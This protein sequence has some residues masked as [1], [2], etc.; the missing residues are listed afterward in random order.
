MIYGVR[1]YRPADRCHRSRYCAGARRFAASVARSAVQICILG[2]VFGTSLYHSCSRRICR[3]TDRA[4]ATRAR[5][6]AACARCRCGGARPCEGDMVV[7][8]LL[9][10]DVIGA[11][12][13]ARRPTGIYKEVER[14]REQPPSSCREPKLREV[15]LPQADG[16][17]L[18]VTVLADKHQI[19][20]AG[21]GKFSIAQHDYKIGRSP[22]DCN[23]RA[24]KQRGGC[25]PLHGTSSPKP[26]QFTFGS[27]SPFS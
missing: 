7:L 19:T 20:A 3:A 16:T 5:C 24:Q 21:A 18:V 4:V 12:G 25:L 22:A 27:S 11:A 14:R 15:V 1:W 8:P 26:S 10:R 23:R 2:S 6:R 13:H 17:L 9:K